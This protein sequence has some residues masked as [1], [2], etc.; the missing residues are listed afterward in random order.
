MI[1]RGIYR[2]RARHSGLY[3]DV[4]GALPVPGIPVIQ[5][6]N[7]GGANQRWEV[8]PL[9]GDL[10]HIVVQL[11]LQQMLAVPDASKD[12]G[13]ILIQWPNTNGDEQKWHLEDVGGGYYTIANAN[14]GF[15]VDVKGN[16]PFQGTPL[17]QWYRNGQQNQMF[18]FENA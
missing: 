5:W 18:S 11:P 7:N 10:Y 12:L 2:I 3:L 16:L 1:T 8:V 9:G 15:V 17:C 13:R 6:P 14:S 4:A